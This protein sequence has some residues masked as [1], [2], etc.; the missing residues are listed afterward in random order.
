M[1]SLHTQEREDGSQGYFAASHIIL[2]LSISSVRKHICSGVHLGYFSCVTFLPT[3]GKQHFSFLFSK[4]YGI[5]VIGVCFTFKARSE[6][7][8]LKAGME[9]YFTPIDTHPVQCL[10]IAALASSCY[11]TAWQCPCSQT[12]TFLFACYPFTIYSTSPYKISKFKRRLG[13]THLVERNELCCM[14]SVKIIPYR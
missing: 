6:F 1:Q 9:A 12:N 5:N 13:K 11:R 4:L 2:S 3:R 10:K 7:C 8:S 14:L